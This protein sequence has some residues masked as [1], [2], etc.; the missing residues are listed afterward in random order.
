MNIFMITYSWNRFLKSQIVKICLRFKKDLQESLLQVLENKSINELLEGDDGNV[1]SQFLSHIEVAEN[2][3]HSFYSAR[4]YKLLLEHFFDSMTLPEFELLPLNFNKLTNQPLRLSAI[5]T[6]SSRFFG[7]TKFDRI[8]NLLL[9]K[10][11]ELKRNR[12]S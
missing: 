9:Q 5:L 12:K 2:S 10:S 11:W 8:R 3:I 7:S 1:L 4:V 6:V